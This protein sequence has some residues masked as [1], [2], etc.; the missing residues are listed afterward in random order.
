MVWKLNSFW[1]FWLELLDA[2]NLDGKSL[3]SCDDDKEFTPPPL[4][5]KQFENYSKQSHYILQVIGGT[6]MHT[7]D[8]ALKRKINILIWNRCTFLWWSEIEDETSNIE[9]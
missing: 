9:Y 6:H 5:A 4:E 2:V 7:D 1:D 8:T 3:D